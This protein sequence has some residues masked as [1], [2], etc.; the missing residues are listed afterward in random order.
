MTDYL[1]T[2]T[3]LLALGFAILAHVGAFAFA[4]T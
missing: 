3:S 1:Y 2:K 4:L